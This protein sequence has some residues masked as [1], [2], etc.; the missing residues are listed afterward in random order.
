M[1]KSGKIQLVGVLVT[2]VL[3]GALLPTIRGLAD[4]VAENG[5]AAEIALYGIISV[6]IAVAVVVGIVKSAG[7][8]HAGQ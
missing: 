8:G 2:L 1:N 4:S 7:I 6:L 5:S 3:L